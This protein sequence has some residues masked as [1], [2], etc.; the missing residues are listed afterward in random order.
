[1]KMKKITMFGAVLA[2]VCVCAGQA[3]A[4]VSAG[5]A[6]REASLARLQGFSDRV[7]AAGDDTLRADAALSAGYSGAQTSETV[8]QDGTVT[9]T[10]TVKPGG[11]A[12][13]T[14][15]PAHPVVAPD[16]VPAPAPAAAGGDVKKDAAKDK[17]KDD[18][19]DKKPPF[20]QQLLAG[21]LGMAVMALFLLLL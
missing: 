16:P 13:V 11:S 19:K 6:A 2:V 7:A 10:V 20:G 4:Q 12:V 18:D 9:I 15:P 8:A 5:A 3:G 1:M 21:F 17:A 14:P